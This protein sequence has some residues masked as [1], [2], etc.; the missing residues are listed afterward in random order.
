MLVAG[1][2]FSRTQFGNNNAYCQDSPISWIDWNL[3][4][5]QKDQLQTVRWLL[6]LRRAHPALRPMAFFSGTD[7]HGDVIADLSWYS[8]DG[9][10][11]RDDIWG[12]QESR[13]FQML[14]SGSPYTGHDALVVFN[15]TTDDRDVVLSQGRGCPWVH[16]FDTAWGNPEDGGISSILDATRLPASLDRKNPGETIS[17][18]PFSMHIYL[19]AVESSPQG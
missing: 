17:L 5:L 18:D 3:S 12:S 10:P 11:M 6:A 4:E 14:R 2:E 8:A 7:P 15:G 1:D 13:V 19:S 9:S 16:V